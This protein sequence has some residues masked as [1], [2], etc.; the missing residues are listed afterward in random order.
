M[1]AVLTFCIINIINFS[2]FKPDSLDKDYYRMGCSFHHGL[3]CTVDN[4]Q[5]RMGNL[6]LLYDAYFLQQHLTGLK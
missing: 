4:Q 3:C 2:G 6:L 5:G 1:F